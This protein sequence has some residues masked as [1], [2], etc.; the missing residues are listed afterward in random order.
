MTTVVSAK[1]FFFQI[2]HNEDVYLSCG[3]HTTLHVAR[4]PAIDLKSLESSFL[5]KINNTNWKLKKI[6]DIFQAWTVSDKHFDKLYYFTKIDTNKGITIKKLIKISSLF[7]YQKIPSIHISVTH[8]IWQTV[9]SIE[10]GPLPFSKFLLLILRLL[11]SLQP[12]FHGRNVHS[13]LP[14]TLIKKSQH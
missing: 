4:G 13:N 5:T 6:C 10:Y 1:I 7:R 3:A 8:R 9:P 14:Q 12:T 11:T 2:R